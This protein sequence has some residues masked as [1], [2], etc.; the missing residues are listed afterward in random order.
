MIIH[1]YTGLVCMYRELVTNRIEWLT[2][3][4][5]IVTRKWKYSFQSMYCTKMPKIYK[6]TCLDERFPMSKF[7][8]VDIGWWAR[9][10]P[11]QK[12]K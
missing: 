5:M 7:P 11:F 8:N 3:S 4:E 9:F 2:L 10:I 1:G 6:Q 12:N